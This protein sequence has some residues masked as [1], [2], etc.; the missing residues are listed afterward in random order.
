MTK[1]NNARFFCGVGLPKTGTTWLAEYLRHHPEVFVPLM[2]EL[3]VF[4]RY[5]RPELYRWMDST[6]GNNLKTTTEKLITK[7]DKRE[8]LAELTSLMAEALALP[9][10]SD[11]KYM[12]KAYRRLFRGR[13]TPE[14]NVFGEFSTT[15]C[16]LPEA[17]LRLLDTAFP[18]TRYLIVLRDPIKRFWSHVKHQTRLKDDFDPCTNY[19]AMFDD[20]ELSEM[21]NYREIVGN[22]LRVIPTDRV[23]IALYEDLFVQH[24]ET[25]LKA[26]TDFLGISY[27]QVD[28]SQ[29]VY[30]GESLPMPEEFIA[31]AC[32]RFQDSY[33]F[34][35]EIFGREP[36]GWTAGFN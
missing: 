20:P 24:D 17:G 18:N 33:R 35:E 15:Y 2:K 12:M 11:E 13:V 25:A 6:I 10:H 30:A 4:N 36:F 5:F 34:G 29:V 21:S 26:I 19:L 1:E 28:Q 31:E 16:V 23:H 22:I 14:H 9:H 8:R 32:A 27:F 7:P 3:Q